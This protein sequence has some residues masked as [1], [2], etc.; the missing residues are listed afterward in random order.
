MIPLLQ[1]V[2]PIIARKTVKV[3]PEANGMLKAQNLSPA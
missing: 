3:I 2:Q 1:Y